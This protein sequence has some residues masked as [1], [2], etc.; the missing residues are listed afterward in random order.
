VICSG[1]AGR[2]V[3]LDT[4]ALEQG[5]PEVRF[6]AGLVAAETDPGARLTFG[7]NIGRKAQVVVSQSL[8]NNGDLTWIVSYSPRSNIELRA[9]SLDSGDRLYGFRHD[10][11]FGSGKTASAPTTAA[12][13][14]RV[15]N[16]QITGAGSDE[17]ELRSRLKLR[18][19]DRFSFFSGRTI[20]IVWS[21]S[22]SNRTAPQ[23]A[24]RPGAL[25]LNG[26]SPGRR[27]ALRRPSRAAH[28]CSS[29]ESLFRSALSTP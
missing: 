12:V 26:R 19:G 23:P 27:A 24:S 11:V 4:S 28:A 21:S 10:L 22:T 13:P 14:P 9:V 2:A 7:K 15:T 5:T 29:P 6:D 1:V 8:Q 16:V 17:P 20:A 3:G 25:R 18:A